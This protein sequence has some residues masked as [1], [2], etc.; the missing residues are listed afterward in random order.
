MAS[1]RLFV[2]GFRF[3]HFDA[4]GPLR[5]LPQACPEPIAQ[6][7]GDQLGLAVNDLEGTLV[8]GRNAHAATVTFL[9]VD[10]DD[11]SGHRWILSSKLLRRAPVLCHSKPPRP[12]RITLSS[13]AER[14]GPALLQYG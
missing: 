10:D 5:T 9:L 7:V 3:P 11:L 13:Q 2:E 12:V 8:A 6:L 1:D 4:E 14:I